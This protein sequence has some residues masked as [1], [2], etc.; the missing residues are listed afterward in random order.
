MPTNIKNQ[1]V[2]AKSCKILECV[3]EH[4][5]QDKKYGRKMR[6]HNAGK[7]H[8]KCTVCGRIIKTQDK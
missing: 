2:G 3:C 4:E 6:V 5:Y 7:E 8:F 1:I